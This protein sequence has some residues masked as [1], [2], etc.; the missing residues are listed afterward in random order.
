MLCDSRTARWSRR[1]LPAIDLY[2]QRV[3]LEWLVVTQK[4]SAG[5]PDIEMEIFEVDIGLL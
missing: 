2:I 1:Y 3:S 5:Q 4:S